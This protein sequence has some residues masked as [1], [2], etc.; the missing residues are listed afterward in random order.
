MTNS[1]FSFSKLLSTLIILALQCDFSFVASLEDVLTSLKGLSAK[2]RLA[3]VER[4]G[5]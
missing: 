1:A 3:R 5:P 4:R 2:E